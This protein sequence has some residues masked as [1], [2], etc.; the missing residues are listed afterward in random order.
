MSKTRIDKAG[1]EEKAR[2]IKLGI[3][4][5]LSKYVVVKQVDGAMPQPA[6]AFKPEKF[7]DWVKK[8]QQQ[9]EEVVTC[10][11][12]GPFGYG[13]HRKLI[14]IG[15]KNVVIRPQNWDELGK[16]VKTDKIDALAMVQRLDQYSRGN[17]MAFA[18]VRP[19][20]VQEEYLRSE[21]RQREQL[22]KHRQQFEAQGRTMMLN[23]GVATK[24]KWWLFRRWE[25]LARELSQEVREMVERFRNFILSLNEE[26]EKLTKK[27]EAAGTEKIKDKRVKALGAFSSEVI[28]REVLDWRRFNNRR[29]VASMTGLCPRVHAS[30][31]KSRQGSITCHGNPRLRKILIESAWM[32]L[33]YQPDYIQVKKRSAQ[34]SGQLSAAKKKA[35]VAIARHLAVDLWRMKT[36]RITADQLGLVMMN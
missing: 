27:I 16:G 12:A 34:L 4:V 30:G 18:V 19:P 8:Q 32:L 7:M 28:D 20:E 5:H 33:R 23:Y 35:V 15:V 14:Q 2:T 24:G 9:S 13:L 17:H 36:G 10:Y 31:E 6:Q 21:S 29:Q 26:I 11:E 3:D 22:R 1:Q 25:T